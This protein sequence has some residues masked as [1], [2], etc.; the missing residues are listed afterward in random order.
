[1]PG[2]F[3]L[4]LI[5]ENLTSSFIKDWLA[6]YI[7][8]LALAI[9]QSLEYIFSK[10]SCFQI[11]LSLYDLTFLFCSV[12]YSVF[13]VFSVL[14]VI[15]HSGFIMWSCLF[16]VLPT[17]LYKILLLCPQTLLFSCCPKY[18]TCSISAFKKIVIS[19]VWIILFI[20][21]VFKSWHSVFHMI[22]FVVR[23]LLD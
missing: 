21:L 22:H 7:F 23:A 6:G 12:Q 9:F 4:F 19:F 3:S 15:C 5:K 8:G 1:M 17:S 10:A 16:G 18:P 2:F 13:C 11:S 20:Y 14:V